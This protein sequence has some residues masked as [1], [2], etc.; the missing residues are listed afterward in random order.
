MAD[1]ASGGPRVL[2][3][4]IV[5]LGLVD[6]IALYAIIVLFLASQWIVLIAIAVVVHRG[7]LHLPSPG[8]SCRPST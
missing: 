3:T 6:A 8:P 7:Q 5:V 1:Q 2:I 4:K